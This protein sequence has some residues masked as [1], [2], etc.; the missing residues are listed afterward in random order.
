MKQGLLAAW[1]IA[2]KDLR[3][4]FRTKESINASASFALVVLVLFSFAFDLGREEFYDI[5]GGLLWLVFSF[6]GAL[7]VN[8]S[9]VRE[10]P[11]DCLDV[12]TASPAPAW[13]LF[14]GKAISGYLL[15]LLVELIS[16]PVFGMFFNI[17]WVGSFW[18]LLVIMVTATWGITIVGTAFSAV[19]VN[20]RLRELMLPVLLYPVLTPMLIGAI[21]MTTAILGGESRGNNSDSMRLIFVFDVMYTSLALYLIVFILVV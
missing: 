1:V 21:Q 16:L 3:T 20:V 6:A 8:R 14:L 13:A 12:L 10:I 15:L 18:Q 5:S 7:I 19:T 2:R 11:N 9:F 4:E 17:Q